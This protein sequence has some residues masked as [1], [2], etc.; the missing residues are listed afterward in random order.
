M[1]ITTSERSHLNFYKQFKFHA[2]INGYDKMFNLGAGYFF[3]VVVAVFFCL[4]F[5]K[6][7][8]FRYNSDCCL[9]LIS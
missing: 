9:S 5:L 7:K 8:I 1:I 6:Q 3:F 4:I 2:Q